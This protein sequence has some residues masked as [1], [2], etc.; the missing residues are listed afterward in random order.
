MARHY[1]KGRVSHKGL[2]WRDRYNIYLRDYEKQEAKLDRQ[3]E[4]MAYGKYTFEEYKNA[5]Q[6]KRDELL[7]E[8][9]IGE[10]NSI[11]NVNQFLVREQAY[12]LSYKAGQG[13]LKHLVE[14]GDIEE[15]TTLSQRVK[16]LT[17]IRQGD[18]LNTS[19]FW[20]AVQE[21]REELYKLYGKYHKKE[22]NAQ[23]SREFFGSK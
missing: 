10:R 21:R 12:E 22:A 16:E 23:I 1:K 13:V 6:E 8:K 11:G 18:Y 19:G 9:N 20:N 7:Y 5:W 17:K 15:P 14:S 3:G 4:K 2:T